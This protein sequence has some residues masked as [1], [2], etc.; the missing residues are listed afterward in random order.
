LDF[1]NFLASDM[2]RLAFLTLLSAPHALAAL[3]ATLPAIRA[4]H[5]TPVVAVSANTAIK[6]IISSNIIFPNSPANCEFSSL[7][8]K[9]PYHLASL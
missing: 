1:E 2:I 9:N 7:R 4:A 8:L 3:I 6:N 5:H